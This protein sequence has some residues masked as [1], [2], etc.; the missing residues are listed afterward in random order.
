[1]RA[2]LYATMPLSAYLTPNVSERMESERENASEWT[3]AS[4]EVRWA[5]E[6]QRERQGDRK[7]NKD[8]QRMRDIGGAAGP[9]R[10]DRGWKLF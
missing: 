1:M 6:G 3:E 7:R 4:A 2:A 9:G 10:E 5:E 8:R